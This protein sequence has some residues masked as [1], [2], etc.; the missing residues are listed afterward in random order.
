MKLFLHLQIC[1]AFIFLSVNTSAQIE[2]IEGLASGAAD[3]I[4]DIDPDA[5]CLAAECCWHDGFFFF[6]FLVEHHE[7]IMDFKDEN[8][9]LLSLELDGSF[10]YSFHYTQGDYF[11]YIDYLPRVRANLGVVSFD[12]R[13]NFLNE[14]ENDTVKSFNSSE[15]LMILNFVPENFLRFSIG[16]GLYYEEFKDVYYMDHYAGVRFGINNNKDFLDIDFRLV[17]SYEND[18]YPFLDLS[19]CYNTKLIDFEHFSA[20]I[21]LGG[22]YQNYYSAHDIWGARG[23]LLLSIH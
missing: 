15:F 18:A 1:V 16:G 23:G 20:Y 2:A 12:Y 13:G 10:A 11:K 21:S 5:C 7:E 19:L 8:S 17:S 3:I 6:G 14:Y 22:V 9:S 4:S